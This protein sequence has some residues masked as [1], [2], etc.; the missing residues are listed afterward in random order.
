MSRGAWL[1]A[2][3]LVSC[4]SADRTMMPPPSQGDGGT[5]TP[6]NC[7]M[8]V[9][10][11]EESSCPAE[12]TCN[13]ALTPPKCQR[14]YCAGE[15][16]TCSEDEHCTPGLGCDETT[17]PPQCSGGVGD[18]CGETF[19]VGACGSAPLNCAPDL[20]CDPAT[21]PPTCRPRGGVGDPCRRHIYSDIS[22]PPACRYLC[23]VTS[24]ENGLA[25]IGNGFDGTCQPKRDRGGFC[26][27]GDECADRRRCVY[28][29]MFSGTCE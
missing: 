4:G 20:V 14:L 21:D 12:S 23:H 15:G 2:V 3:L 6:A 11:S 22:E 1:L 25:C 10:C 26:N 8:D 5:S 27:C 16:A 7:T 13:F 29:A 17:D 28:T 9:V 19:T 24:C 18:T